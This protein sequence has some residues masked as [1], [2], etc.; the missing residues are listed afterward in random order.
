MIHD[1]NTILRVRDLSKRFTLHERGRTIQAFD[2]LSFDAAP[3]AMTVM[4]GAS[5]SGKSSALK[6][7]YRTYT[8]DHGKVGYLT[9]AGVWTDLATADTQTVLG[10]RRSEIRFVSQFLKALPR[11]TSVEV[12]APWR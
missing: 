11:K 9:A 7:I 1:D 2:G 12:V 3:G 4:V 6:C 10:L 8:T 5:G